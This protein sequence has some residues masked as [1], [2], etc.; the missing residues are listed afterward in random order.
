M[1]SKDEIALASRVAVEIYE[2]VNLILHDHFH[3]LLDREAVHAPEVL[4]LHSPH[5]TYRAVPAVPHDIRLHIMSQEWSACRPESPKP[6][7]GPCAHRRTERGRRPNGITVRGKAQF[8]PM[9]AEGI[10]WCAMNTNARSIS[11]KKAGM[12]GPRLFERFPVR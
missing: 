12:A 1:H 8:A 11:A 6:K 4:D 3:R 9:A 2:D 10:E 7:I 5:L